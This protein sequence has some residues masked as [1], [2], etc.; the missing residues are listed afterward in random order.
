MSKGLAAFDRFLL[1]LI[2]VVLIALGLWPILIHFEVPFATSLARWVDHDAWAALP[3]ANWW[4]VALGAATMLLAVAGIW[5]IVA[6][7]RHRRFNNVASDSS[8]DEGAISTNMQAIAGA[9]AKSF[10]ALDGVEK[11]HRLVAYDRA[12]PTLQYKIEAS[13]D[14][15]LDELTKAVETSEKDFRSAF[16]DA[17]LDTVYKLH[18]S[19]VKA[20]K[21]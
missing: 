1:F 12:R 2:A 11:V 21:D 16:P 6:N 15:P 10:D 9:V 13:A 18:F 3:S 20:L 5:L 19:Q 7:L 14:M 17:N 8:N 4:P